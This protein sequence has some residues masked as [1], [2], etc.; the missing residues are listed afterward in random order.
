MR[1]HC[2]FLILFI[3]TDLLAVK[4]LQI[5]VERVDK[6]MSSLTVEFHGGGHREKNAS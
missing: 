6:K 3:D 5:T 1:A 4:D 2:L